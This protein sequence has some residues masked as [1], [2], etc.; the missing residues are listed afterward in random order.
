ML[1]YWGDTAERSGGTFIAPDSVEVLARFFSGLPQGLHPSAKPTTELVALCSEFVDT[2]AQ[3]GD[4]IMCHPYMLHTRSNNPSG[5]PRYLTNGTVRL[6][7]PMRFDRANPDDHSLVERKTLR[8]LGVESF[9]FPVDE[10][11]RTGIAPYDRLGN[12]ALPIMPPPER[13][14]EEQEMHR[15][16]AEADKA[17]ITSLVPELE[18]Q[19]IAAQASAKM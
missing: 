15:L 18:C 12:G 19:E 4:V 3:A 13:T 6:M 14:E 17:S 9:H 8:A 16:A 11:T 10:A 1:V 7:K 5:V 2:T